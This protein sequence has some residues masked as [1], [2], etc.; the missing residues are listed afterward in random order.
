[1]YTC[2]P[3]VQWMAG[4]LSITAEKNLVNTVKTLIKGGADVNT[5]PEK[6]MKCHGETPLMNAAWEGHYDIVKLLLKAGAN[7]TPLVPTRKRIKIRKSSLYEPNDVTMHEERKGWTVLNLA[8]MKKKTD[9]VKMILERGPEGNCGETALTYA[10][11]NGL[12]E[13]VKELLLRGASLPEILD[14]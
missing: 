12:S 4:L 9:V 7:V 6:G 13:M 11:R 10:L 3:N 2:W 8:C 14:T 5:T 1:M